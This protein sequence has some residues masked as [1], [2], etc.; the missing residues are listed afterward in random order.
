MTG[1][2]SNELLGRVSAAIDIELDSTS[3]HNF[4]IGVSTGWKRI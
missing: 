4:G 3:V 2:D 1:R